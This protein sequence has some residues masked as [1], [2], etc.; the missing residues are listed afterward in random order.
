M[1]PGHGER[2]VLSPLRH[3]PASPILLHVL[4]YSPI[5]ELSYIGR[6]KKLERRLGGAGYEDVIDKIKN[7]K[8]DLVTEEYNKE[9]L[10]KNIMNELGSAMKSSGDE[11]EV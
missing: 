6:G 4:I 7:Q 3:I 10:K 11:G 9:L 2:Q 8:T 1:T 5:S